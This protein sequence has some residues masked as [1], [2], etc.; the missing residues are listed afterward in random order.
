MRLRSSSFDKKLVSSGRFSMK[1]GGTEITELMKVNVERSQLPKT[2]SCTVSD[3][4]NPI[5]LT[6][7]HE[8]FSCDANPMSFKVRFSDISSK[9]VSPLKSTFILC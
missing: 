9:I 2:S 8:I 1:F 6:A 4:P 3:S 5:S 7:E